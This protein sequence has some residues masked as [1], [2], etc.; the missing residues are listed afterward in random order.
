MTDP[1]SPNEWRINATL[2]NIPEFHETYNV[3]EGDNMYRENPV[4]MW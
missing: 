1:H 4:Q 2:A 3:K